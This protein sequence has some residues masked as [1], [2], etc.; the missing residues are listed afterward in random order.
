V[1][2]VLY[3]LS[4]PFRALFAFGAILVAAV[5]AITGCA[6]VHASGL[7]SHSG[8]GWSW[9]SAGAFGGLAADGG[10]TFP[11]GD[12]AVNHVDY[13]TRPAGALSGKSQMTATFR[14]SGAPAFQATPSGA[15]PIPPSAHL[16]FAKQGYAV[17]DT[18]ALDFATQR[19]WS[20]PIYPA[21]KA[22]ETTITVPLVA[23]Q[24]S[25]VWGMKGDA[26]MAARAAFSRA[27]TEAGEIGLTFGGGC[28]FGHG[29]NVASGKAVFTLVRLEAE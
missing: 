23:G 11:T 1:N 25:D 9:W 2:R 5:L 3:I 8:H 22:G 13:L 12:P 18:G 28:A 20:N 14:I 17:T 19:W 6:S 27:L 4:L 10:F 21:L 24:W 16:F 15:C 26:S 7:A 29:V